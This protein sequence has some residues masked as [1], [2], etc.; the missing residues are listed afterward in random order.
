MKAI[1]KDRARRYGSASDLAADAGR[2]LRHE[3]VAARPPSASY[4]IH[5]F[6]RRHRTGV[7]AAL[8]V[9]AA[10][11]AG[12]AGTAMGIVKARS[13]AQTAH[14]VS[15]VLVGLFADLDPGAPMGQISSATAMLDRGVERIT[16][17]LAGQPLVQARLLETVGKAYRNLGRF[18]EARPP[19]EQALRLREA[20]LGAIHAAVAD[21]CVDLG[22]LE[23]WTA[24]FEQAR[25]LFERAVT[26]YEQTLGPA[27]A[28]S[29]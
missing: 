14:Q 19:L 3:P 18:D 10:L 7:A 5:K 20:N 17:E 21:S 15:E 8:L 4:R 6:M 22:W 2:Y 13:E 1:E 9:L 26:I 12:V 16:S 25:T 27:H 28:D 24:D 11:L 23:Y 29:S